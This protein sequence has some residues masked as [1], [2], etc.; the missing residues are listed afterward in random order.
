VIITP[1]VLVLVKKLKAKVH[2]FRFEKWWLEVEGF[3]EL[4]R[5]VCDSE[6]PVSDPID[7]WQF[8]I[9]TLRK[10]VRGWSRNM[11]VARNRRK[12]EILAEIDLLDSKGEQTP[13]D[14]H[15]RKKKDKT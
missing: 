3:E 1:L 7:K 2:A 13:L 9:R 8:K 10:N 14:P 6:C 12:K 4:V 5:K 11:K 15:Q